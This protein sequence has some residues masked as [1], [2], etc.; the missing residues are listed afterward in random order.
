MFKIFELAFIQFDHG[1]PDG[2]SIRLSAASGLED[3][4][5]IYDSLVCVLF[6]FMSRLIGKVVLS[7]SFD[8]AT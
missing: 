5:Q 2:P 7:R 4:I 6:A 8:R 3:F 1:Y